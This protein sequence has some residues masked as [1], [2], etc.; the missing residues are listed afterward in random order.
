MSLNLDDYPNFKADIQGRDTA[1]IPIIKIGDIYIS[2][3]SM[4]YDGQPILPLLTSNP[5][6][7]ESIDIETRRYKISNISITI[8]NYPYE[9]QRFSERV[10]GEL[11]NVPFTV[12]WT[13]PSVTNF[14]DA[15]MIYQGQVR[16]YDH[17]DASCRITAED[18][19]QKTLHK[20]LPIANLGTGSEVPDKY[21]NKPIPMVYGHVDK[22]PCVFKVETLPDI[23]EYSALKNIIADS[24]PIAS[25]IDEQ[26]SL[27][28]H[29]DLDIFGGLFIG[30]SSLGYAPCARTFMYSLTSETFYFELPRV[31]DDNQNYSYDSANATIT[32]NPDAN[33]DISRG[34]LRG[35]IPRVPNDVKIHS[36]L[37]GES[38]FTAIQ[39]HNITG[40]AAEGYGDD[41]LDNIDI[42]PSLL[43]AINNN[44]NQGVHLGSAGATSDGSDY[45]AIKIELAPTS[46]G[47]DADSYFIGAYFHRIGVDLEP[48]GEWHN[49]PN[50]WAWINY[51]LL[52]PETIDEWLDSNGDYWFSNINLGD[53]N[54][55]SP[56]TK[57]I[58]YSGTPSSIIDFNLGVTNYETVASPEDLMVNIDVWS[59]NI[60]HVTYIDKLVDRDFYANVKGRAIG[61]PAGYFGYTD[62]GLAIGDLDRD[63][64]ITPADEDLIGDCVNA[65]NCPALYL[66]TDGYDGD[67]AD[68]NG[69]GFWNISD[70]TAIATVIE[71]NPCYS[72]TIIRDILE[73]ELNQTNINIEGNYW[74]S[75][76]FTVDKKINSKKL[77]ENIASASPYIPRFNNMG[78]FVFTEIPK[79]G[80]VADFEI[81][82]AD[83][84]DFSFSRTKIEDVYTKV[85]LK[86]NW[87]YAKGEFNDSISIEINN[88]L[89]N[90]RNDYY[91]LTM[92][93]GSDGEG[94]LIHP[95]STLIIDGEQG[96]YIR[97][98]I[99]AY[100]F[101]AWYLMWSCNQHLKMKVKL[102]LK[103][104]NLE[105]GDLIEFD[106][107]L[108]GVE[109][110][111]INYK[112]ADSVNSQN[113]YPKFLITETNKT[114]EFVEI[115]CIQMHN[116]S[117]DAVFGCTDDDACNYN[118]E[119]TINDNSCVYADIT[120]CDGSSACEEHDCTNDC[121]EDC[122]DG[123]DCAGVCDGDAELDDCGGD[124]GGC[125]NRNFT[126]IN[127]EPCE[128]GT[129]D[130]TLPN[131]DCDCD[132]GLFD[133]AGVCAGSAVEDE[134]GVCGGDNSTCVCCDVEGAHNHDPNCGE[135][136]SVADDDT[137]I[138]DYCI[139]KLN[140]T[141]FH[142]SIGTFPLYPA[143]DSGYGFCNDFF[144]ESD[145]VGD[146]ITTINITQGSEMWVYFNA[147]SDAQYDEAFNLDFVNVRFRLESDDERVTILLNNGNWMDFSEACTPFNCEGTGTM[148]YKFNFYA[149]WQEDYDDLWTF[150]HS[151]SIPADHFGEVAGGW[152]GD[153]NGDG[154]IDMAVQNLLATCL[155]HDNCRN[156]YGADGDIADINQDDYWNDTDMVAMANA[157]LAHANT[158]Y[159]IEAVFEITINDYNL[160]EEI[161]YEERV[162]YRF[163]AEECVAVG[164]SNGD[165]FW[166]VLDIVQLANCVLL[167]SCP[168]EMYACAMDMQND[169][170]YNVL[171]IVALANCIL[172]DSCGG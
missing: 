6:L 99:T 35:I 171:D 159:T 125:G 154:I 96:K 102:P 98:E 172:I 62:D 140:Q 47:F 24:V 129:P 45:H 8:S 77:I 157:I 170:F 33:N 4:I 103:Y 160:G 127:G 74:W 61:I 123:Y 106:E 109:P 152:I 139:P 82:E 21:K 110:Y 85:V 31:D 111:K 36:D 43:R 30:D 65:D 56:F 135:E 137:C 37:T 69:D 124:D 10:G 161:T 169:G 71:D 59:A 162:P 11:M 86:Y 5:S 51:E 53:I 150:P 28:Q 2:T 122:P 136:G 39:N 90:Y 132:N 55:S 149:G 9:G 19:S 119:A 163:D 92:P 3:N 168:N 105:I 14:N 79:T 118:H 117:D 18:R 130:C 75:Y 107:V 108:G 78:D 128:Q 29:G 97:S 13:S 26:V 68:I 155:L 158:T 70:I 76:A 126:D 151:P 34:L 87:D 101:A 48:S 12:Y 164:D 104:M 50:V 147:T 93:E 148:W 40:Y 1:L 120:C 46:C 141:N 133:C 49:Y 23:P 91:G 42:I 84:I 113:V 88:I 58:N 166:N 116:L 131:G 112:T 143:V 57:K 165:G 100:Q 67:I 41:W 52:T 83:V 20:D 95:D 142:L 156:N 121:P 94:G 134:C 115:S 138:Y 89:G 73:N 60:F 72:Q 81:K 44:I 27:P 32:L 144:S 145:Q 7:K 38:G 16:R 64:M 17:N 66:A 167:D 22:S 15:L 25:F 63:G 80:G 153:L 114:L 54:Q 146:I